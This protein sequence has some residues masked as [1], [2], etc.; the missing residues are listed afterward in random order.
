MGNGG[1]EG[2]GYIGQRTENTRQKTEGRRRNA[3]MEKGTVGRRD[4]GNGGIENRRQRTEG[5]KEN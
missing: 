2:R 3:E 4:G 1:T 5:G